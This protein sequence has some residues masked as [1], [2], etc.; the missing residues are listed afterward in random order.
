M[1]RNEM[2]RCFLASGSVR[3]R[4]KIQS[5]YWPSV[6]QVFWPLTTNSS[7]SRTAVVRSEARSEPAS[8]SEKPC[9][10]Q[11]SRLAVFGRNRSLSSCEPNAAITG[12]TM[13]ALNASGVGTHARCISSCQMWR[14]SGDQS[15][16]PHSTGQCGTA[17]PCSLRIRWLVTIW[18]LVSSRRSATASRISCG[19][20]GGEEGP[21]LLAERGVLGGQL[22]AA[23]AV[24]PGIRGRGRFRPGPR[25]GHGTQRVPSAPARPGYRPVVRT[26]SARSASACGPGTTW[27]RGPHAPGRRRATRAASAE[28]ATRTPEAVGVAGLDGQA[29]G[30]GAGG[31][32]AGQHRAAERAADGADVGVHARGDAGLGLRDGVDDEVRHRREREAEGQAEHRGLDDDL[33]ELVV[34]DGQ[35][36][37]AQRGQRGADDEDGLGAVRRGEPPG[38]EAGDEGG[39]GLRQQQQPGLGDGDAEAVAGE[40]GRLQELGEEGEHRVHAH[41]EQQGHQVHG[42][43]GR[44]P[45]HPHVDQRLG[46]ARL[47]EHPDRQ[48]DGGDHEQAEHPARS[49]SP[50]RDPGSRRAA[51]R[52]ASRRAAARCR[53]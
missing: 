17:R 19:T 3:T 48:Q 52:R 16:P 8:G 50:R 13:E 12:P 36:Q 14:R 25:A 43:H 49:P 44:D 5:P 21:H 40:L 34:Q 20:C 51:A 11:M 32:D 41:A 33:P 38:E 39:R 22:R 9:D 18:S 27:V 15:R 53:R 10:H 4:Q 47:G 31:D 23:S 46:A 35:A 29:V 1:S 2:P 30:P 37:R 7:P 45:H 26:A 42:P 28:V 6:V 24:P